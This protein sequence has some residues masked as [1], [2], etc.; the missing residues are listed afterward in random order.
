M[1]SLTLERDGALLHATDTGTFRPVVFQHGL[2]GSEAQVAEMFPDGEG[3]RRLTLECRGHGGSA[4][5]PVER[6]SIRTFAED[7]LALAERLEVT[8]FVA[9]GISMGAALALRLAV[10]HPA[11]V[12]ALILVRPA[13]MF[14]SAPPSMAPF[15][16]VAAL[17]RAQPPQQARERFAATEPGVTL[18]RTAPDNYASLL[19]FFD[20]RPVSATVELLSRIAADGPGVSAADTAGLAMPV[21]VIGNADDAVHPLATARVLA[22]TIPG[23]EFREVVAKSSDRARHADAVRALINAFCHSDAV[24]TRLE[25]TAP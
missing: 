4:L 13:W 18:R 17:L 1:T 7:V 24:K 2:G 6:L 23:A 16:V 20:R 19:G 11:R 25:T 3:L 8:R 10:L 5:G 9:G 12:A 21:L 14:D 22:H 15:A